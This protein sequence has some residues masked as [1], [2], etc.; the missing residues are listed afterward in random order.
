VI[1][2]DTASAVGAVIFGGHPLDDALAAGEVRIEG[3]RRAFERYVGL[4]PL[5]EPAE[6]PVAA[7][8]PAA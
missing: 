2:A 6:P 8:R 1:E 4:F 3:D 5:P 7:E